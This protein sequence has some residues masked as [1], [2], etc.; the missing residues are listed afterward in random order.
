LRKK[1]YI[2]D[3]IEGEEESFNEALDRGLVFFNEELK[4]ITTGS[5][6]FSCGCIQAA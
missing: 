2:R 6:Q 1:D 5:E 3:I 4:M